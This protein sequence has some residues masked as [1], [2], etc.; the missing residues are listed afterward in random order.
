M[1]LY[2]LHAWQK[3]MAQ[4][5]RI[6]SETLHHLYT[7]PL[8][9]LAYT[10]AG[11][12]MAASAEMFERMTRHFAKPVFNLPTTRIDG[13]EVAVT[14]EIVER[15][16]FCQLR[17]FKRDSGRHDPKVLLVAPMSGHFATLLRGTVQALL[18]AHDVYIT[19]WRDAR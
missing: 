9:P 19:D 14:E 10:R 11:R 15:R 16:T 1:L 4:P 2:Q 18:P 7:H 13:R 17:H 3:Q 12:A 8:N 5:L 6:A